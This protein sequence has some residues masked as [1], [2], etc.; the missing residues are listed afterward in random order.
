MCAKEQEAMDLDLVELTLLPAPG[1]PRRV[2]YEIQAK[3]VE[4][5]ENL[6]KRGV[7]VTTVIAHPTGDT[8]MGQFVITLGPPAITAIAAVARAWVQTRFGRRMRFKFDDVEAEVRTVQ[9]IDGL[10]KRLTAFRDSK[11]IAREVRS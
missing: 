9:E 3:L 8:N 1:D 7:G 4:I 5:Q 10:L 6:R 2:C 11:R